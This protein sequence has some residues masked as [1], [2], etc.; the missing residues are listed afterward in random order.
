MKSNVFNSDQCY[1]CIVHN[2]YI[3]TLGTFWYDVMA[4]EAHTSRDKDKDKSVII[5]GLHQQHRLRC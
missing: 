5:M 1:S 4:Q 2:P 3:P